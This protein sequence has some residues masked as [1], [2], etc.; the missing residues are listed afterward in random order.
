MRTLKVGDVVRFFDTHWVEHRALVT[1]VWGEPNEEWMPC[2]NLV[3]ISSDAAKTD[4]YGRQLE[5]DSSVAHAGN[6]KLKANSY[7]LEGEDLS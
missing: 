5:R 7:L 4:P 3:Y 2:I 1:A 6:T